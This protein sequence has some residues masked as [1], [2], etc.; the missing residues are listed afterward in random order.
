MCG[1]ASVGVLEVTFLFLINL[2]VNAGID[3]WQVS[4]DTHTELT[5]KLQFFSG[6]PVT[7]NGRTPSATREDA[8]SNSE[9]HLSKNWA[10]SD[11]KKL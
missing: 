10:R 6:R 1:R 4:Q 3:C 11:V 5:P 8:I 2:S 9:V 7:K